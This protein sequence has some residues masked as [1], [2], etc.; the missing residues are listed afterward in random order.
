MQSSDFPKPLQE[1]AAM[2]QL[3]VL[4]VTSTKTRCQSLKAGL[5]SGKMEI[6]WFVKKQV[7]ITNLG[8]GVVGE[9][10]YGNLS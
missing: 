10:V 7:K 1:G 5:R 3:N 8:G 6:S 2:S 9:E 4:G